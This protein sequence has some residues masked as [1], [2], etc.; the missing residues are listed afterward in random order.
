LAG[1][2]DQEKVPWMQTFYDDIFLWFLLAAAILFASY[3]V[4]GLMEQASWAGG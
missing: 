1:E 4:W 3:T 2:Q